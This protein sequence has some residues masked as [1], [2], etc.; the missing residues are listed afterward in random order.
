M[1][2]HEQQDWHDP[3]PEINRDIYV[4][5]TCRTCGV[6][7]DIIDF[8]DGEHSVN[9]VEKDGETQFAVDHGELAHRKS[10]QDVL[11]SGI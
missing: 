2:Q 4:P 7:R 8:Y 1:A 9:V 10:M 3:D 6:E 5:Y 11:D